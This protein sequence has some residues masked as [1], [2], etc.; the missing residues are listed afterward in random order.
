MNSSNHAAAMADLALVMRNVVKPQ[1]RER[2]YFADRLRYL[3][4]RF[5]GK[6]LCLS[7]AIGCTDAAVS[8]WG[9]GKRLPQARTFYRILDALA[10]E[11]VSPSELSHL[12]ASWREASLARDH[13]S[14]HD[15]EPDSS[16]KSA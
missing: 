6:Q 11:G 4:L 15:L 16:R 8:F 2:S 7:H 3:R 9:S 5:L 14:E 10:H 1:N 13:G 12:H